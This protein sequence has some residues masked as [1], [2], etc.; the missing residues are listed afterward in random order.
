M[1]INVHIL[2]FTPPLPLVR[3]ALNWS[4][5]EKGR[6]EEEEVYG[7]FG[8]VTQSEAASLPILYFPPAVHT[9]IR[10][11]SVIHSKPQSHTLTARHGYS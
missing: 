4:E 8:V 9:L 2:T 10:T 5:R 3:Y 6:R 7:N 11:H 1:N